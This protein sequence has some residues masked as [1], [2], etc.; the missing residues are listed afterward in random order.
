MPIHWFPWGLSALLACLAGLALLAARRAGRRSAELR[1]D[2]LSAVRTL[3][4]AVDAADPFTRGHA[5]RISRACLDMARHLGVPERDWEDLEAAALLHDIG[6]A[7]NHQRHHKHSQ[8]LIVNSDIPG[9]TDRERLIVGAMARFHR[10]SRPD[11]THEVMEPFNG[12]EIR[13]IRKC[14]ALLRIADSLDRSHHQPV[15]RL[16]VSS[17]GRTVVLKVR[18]KESIDLELWDVAH[19]QGLFREVFGR[20]LLVERS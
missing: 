15:K 13:V 9:L 6:H 16:S 2:R 8:Y 5:E 11:P 14:A 1:R 17:R 3:I 19:E 20:G 4:S 12:S 18:A 7:V 10:R